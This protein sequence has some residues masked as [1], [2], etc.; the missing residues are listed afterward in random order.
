MKTSFLTIGMFI[1]GL[2]LGLATPPAEG[3]VA[4]VAT[5]QNLA[6]IAREVA[7]DRAEVI[8]LAPGDQDVHMVEPRPSWVMHLRRADVLVCVGMDL[9]LWIQGLVDASRNRRIAR[10]APGDVDASVG[11]RKLEVPTERLDPSMGH[12]HVYGNPHYDLDPRNGKAIAR[13]ILEA[14]SRADPAG[15]QVYQANFEDFSR[16]LDQAVA[17]W[18]AQLRPHRGADIVVYH[19]SW[20]YF[21]DCFGL[22]QFAEIEPKP[23]VPPSPAHA[24]AVIQRMNQA[25]VKTVLMESYYPRRFPQMIAR[26]TGARL[27]E[28]PISVRGR[29][30]IETYFDLFDHLVMS[31]AR[32]LGEA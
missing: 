12:I 29:R 10:G 3:R 17:R 14:L 8:G 9:D 31:I 19:K 13:R 4:V 27:L 18:Q 21:F 25:G 26:E 23:G 11:I 28:V 32:A 7:G 6:A 22:R 24:H 1:S 30:G 20:A 15:A 16:R 2:A 5:T